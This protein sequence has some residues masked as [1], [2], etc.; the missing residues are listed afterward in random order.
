M[1]ERERERESDTGLVDELTEREPGCGGA[2]SNSLGARQS[3]TA[4][5]SR[6]S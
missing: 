4:T 3:N 6:H 5:A 2:K 1:R